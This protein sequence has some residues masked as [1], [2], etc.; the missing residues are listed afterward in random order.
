MNILLKFSNFIKY[1]FI[2]FK[3][4]IKNKIIQN[5][6]KGAQ[7]IKNRIPLVKVRKRK[8][9]EGKNKII[10]FFFGKKIKECQR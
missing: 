1:F 2:I 6:R 10:L 9:Y 4:K 3:K 8:K 7:K 5:I